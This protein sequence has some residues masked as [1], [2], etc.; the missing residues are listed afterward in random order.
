MDG[1]ADGRDELLGV[2]GDED[3]HADDLRRLPPGE[4]QRLR[5]THHEALDGVLLCDGLESFHDTG[6][7][8]GPRLVG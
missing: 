6:L 5:L 3:G 1:G 4:V 7:Q 8:V 2:G